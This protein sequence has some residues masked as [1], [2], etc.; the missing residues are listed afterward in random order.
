MDH[1]QKERQ[2]RGQDF[3]EE[4]RR[5]WR[6]VPN[7]WRM[8]IADGRGGTRPADE[9]VLLS[10]INVLAELKRTKGDRFNLGMLEV[11]QIRGLLDF[12]SVID[13]NRGLV[14]VSFLDEARGVDL[15]VAFRLI[16][17]AKYMKQKN[18]KYISIEEFKNKSIPCLWLERIKLEDGPGYDLKGV[19][20]YFATD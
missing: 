16:P 4:L 15:A 13:R 14:F 10:D 8:R 1:K 2:Q 9:I 12:D 17:A 7:C 6:L 18:K 20:G 11:N 3:Q 19:N 5:S